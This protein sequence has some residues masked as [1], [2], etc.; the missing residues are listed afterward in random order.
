MS[1]SCPLRTLSCTTARCWF[2]DLLRAA[3]LSAFCFWA[4][5]WFCSRCCRFGLL[6]GI[7]EFR[8]VSHEE[9]SL[10]SADAP[11]VAMEISL[12]SHKKGL[13]PFLIIEKGTDP[14]WCSARHDS[15][16]AHWR[17]GYGFF[18]RIIADRSANIA[19]YNCPLDEGLCLYQE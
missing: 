2:C 12:H 11:Q 19:C 13:S 14:R 18:Y 16:C 17:S 7:W 4:S 9:D 5:G 3:W 6:S 8:C 10:L 1:R 15:V